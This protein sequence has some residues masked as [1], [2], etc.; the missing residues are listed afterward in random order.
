M[1]P[2]R[3]FSDMMRSPYFRSGHYEETP[4]GKFE[5]KIEDKILKSKKRINMLFFKL[6]K[7]ILNDK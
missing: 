3:H 1:S 2:R 7:K 4:G 6:F 5:K